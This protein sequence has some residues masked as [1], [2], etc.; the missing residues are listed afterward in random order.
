MIE[1]TLLLILFQKLAINTAVSVSVSAWTLVAISVERYFAI[2]HPLRSR[3]WQTLSHAYKLITLIWLGS[4]AAMAPVAALS[5]LQ[6]TSQ[7]RLNTSRTEPTR[8]SLGNF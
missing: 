7:E 1:N 6:P 3:R 8:N 4:L 5:E 2:C